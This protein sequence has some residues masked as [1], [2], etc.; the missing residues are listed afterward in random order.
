MSIP[1][2]SAHANLDDRTRRCLGVVA[3]VWQTLHAHLD[4]LCLIGGW[5]VYALSEAS[6]LTGTRTLPRHRGSLDVDIALAWSE[7]SAATAALVAEK[8]KAAQYIEPPEGSFRW[9]RQH[10]EDPEPFE[11]DLMATHPPDHEAGPL[12]VGGYV[13][14]PFWNGE[15]A[16]AAPEQFILHAVLPSGQ[17]A[18]QT[19]TVAGRAGLLYAKA[20]IPF[21]RGVSPAA[22]DKHL[23][24]VY[25]LL[26]TW[27]GG[28][29]VA[30]A[31]IALQLGDEAQMTLADALDAAFEART[32]I[33]PRAVMSAIGASPDVEDRILAEAQ[34]G[35]QGVVSE[36]RRG[37]CGGERPH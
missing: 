9:S 30:A 34:A 29:K 19:V 32:G 22:R 26:R 23:E 3:E 37:H 5:A 1:V 8:L 28:P 11:I 13:L 2:I 10:P 35:V 31:E 15:T 33:G 14:A 25:Y 21:A 24:D 18:E 20:Q 17:M 27:P 16:L 36:L 12:L 7:L 6:G 4:A